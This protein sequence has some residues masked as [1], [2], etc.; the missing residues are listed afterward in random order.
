VTHRRRAGLLF[1]VAILLASIAPPAIAAGPAIRLAEDATA[2]N[3]RFIVAWRTRAPAS[4]R[5]D[6]VA[7]VAETAR[8]TRSVVTA[9]KGREAEVA[10]ALRR[11]PRVLAVVPDARLKSQDWPAD[12]VPNDPY[13]YVQRNLDTI[14]VAGAWRTTTGD[15]SVVV[16]VLDTGVDLTHP[17]I[18]GV[19]VVAP[20]NVLDDTTDVYDRFGHGTHVAGTII[21]R[22]DNGEGM[23]G[24]APGVSLMPVKVLDEFGFG[25]LSDVM[26]GIDWAANHGADIINMSL[27][28]D[29]DDDEIALFQS[30]V[31][32]AH[33][34][35]ALLVAAAGN[36]GSARRLYPASLNDVVSVAATDP[37][38]KAASFSQRNTAVD[39]AA[40]GVATLS[41]IPRG[42][43]DFYTGTSMAASQVSGAAALLL[44]ARPGLVPG[45]AEAV[46]R[47]SARDVGA[48]GYDIYVGDGIV[49]VAAALETDVPNPLPELDPPSAGAFAVTI[50]S[51]LE[52]VVIDGVTSYDFEI[53]ATAEPEDAEVVE[54][55]WPAPGNRCPSIDSRDYIDFFYA[56]YAPTITVEGITD[57]ICARIL[58]GAISQDGV[59][60]EA[61]SPA[62]I[63]ADHTAPRITSRSP[64][65]G[66][67]D[68]PG[69]RTLRV[70]VSEQLRGVSA[71][72]VRLRDLTTGKIVRARVWFNFTYREIRIDP[73]WDLRHARKY[74][75]EILRGLTDLAGN[76][77]P[78]SSW[79][80]KTRP[81]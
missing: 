26:D 6:G 32:G 49:D 18:Y 27:G 19:D 12:G 2:Y 80:F 58:V 81:W 23:T 74:Q 14:N 28:G 47:A 52:D 33:D 70:K 37:L 43:Y 34:N 56:D 24:M 57:S 59:Y 67:T 65:I 72:T 77:L 46:L 61:I 78:G 8:P 39:I 17:D 42:E 44:S 55:W 50:T 51:P 66:Q 31:T 63:G 41:T 4:V 54:V 16:A 7:R 10:A 45:E 30:V 9:S 21:A 62:V 35:G 20:H 76:P 68:Y 22:A 25:S 13:N 53:T 40:P 79:R 11:D 5:I 3:G 60:S 38:D 64:R 29:L 1:G 75:V 69:G 36:D 73:A 15:P 48:S 71:A